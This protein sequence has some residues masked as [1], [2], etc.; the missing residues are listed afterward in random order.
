[1]PERG[2]PEEGPA[3][4]GQR[5]VEI[6]NLVFTQFERQDGGVLK[7]LPQK[8]IDTGAGFE[9]ICR[10]MQGGKTNFDTDLFQPILTRIGAAAGEPY[11]RDPQRDIKMRRIADHVRAAL[12]CI[13]DGVRPSNEQRGYVVRKILRRALADWWQLGVREPGLWVLVDA[14]VSVD[15]LA[16]QY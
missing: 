8:N 14:V 11:G 13:A 16:D 4:D 5:F 10:V 15:G 12:F 7:P 6:W 2:R 1:A 3:I 9:R